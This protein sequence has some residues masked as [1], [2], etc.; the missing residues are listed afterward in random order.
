MKNMNS[1]I[2]K[3]AG[4]IFGLGLLA[5]C[6]AE[7]Q[8]VRKFY[9]PQL[10]ERPR[11]EW[12]KAY[13]SQLDFPRSGFKAFVSAI[14]GT[15]D[16]ILF[17][18][19][20]DI[21][22]NGEGK[23]YV[24]DPMAG[25]VYVYDMVEGTVHLLGGED[26]VGQFK[27]PVGL[28]LDGSLNIYVSDQEKL[29]ILVF[30][31]NEKP[32]RAIPLQGVLGRPTGMAFDK[33]RNRLYVVDIKDHRIGVFSPE[34]TLLSTIGKRGDEDGDLNF[35]TAVA[36]NSKGEIIVA[37]SMN[38]RIQIFDAEGKFLR[39]FGRR[40]DG[41]SDFQIVKGVAVD[42]DDNIYV[43]E[44]K[45]HKMLIFST[46]GDFLLLVGGLYSVLGSGKAAPGGFLIPQGI[47]IDKNDTIYVVDQLN[48]RFQVFQYLSDRYL[49]ANPV[50]GYTP[51]KQ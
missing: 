2:K 40:G 51:P 13:S 24:S 31:R 46:N 32:L 21:K 49:Q 26:A 37:D 35:P 12:K 36:V 38:A 33:Q 1:T 8:E 48:K 34:G 25:V 27:N 41:P 22:S 14:A 45:G 47:D 17:S 9:W 30:D 10:P 4:L 44:G 7:Q 39:K 18:K 6:A 28:T 16:P 15:E 50:P 42:S 29:M 5:G 11:I 43:T 23:V 3:L 20:V 19:P